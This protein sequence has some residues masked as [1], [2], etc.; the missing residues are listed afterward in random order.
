MLSGLLDPA[1]RMPHARR[2]WLVFGG[3]IMAQLVALWVLCSHQVRVAEARQNQRTVQQLAL[4][5]CLQ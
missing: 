2:F 5:D 4:A 3:L 1:V